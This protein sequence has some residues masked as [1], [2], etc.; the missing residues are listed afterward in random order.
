MCSIA[1]LIALVLATIAIVGGAMAAANWGGPLGWLAAAALIAGAI[2]ML[3]WG[4][5]AAFREYANCRDS[6]EGGSSCG[7]TSISNLLHAIRVVLGITATSFLTAAVIFWNIF[8]GGPVAATIALASGLVGCGVAIGLLLALL[9]T[10][11]SYKA[12]RDTE[13]RHHA[14]GET[15]ASA[16][17]PPPGQGAGSLT[18][19]TTTT[20]PVTIVIKAG[21]GTTI[22]RTP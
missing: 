19:T 12:C 2:A 6:A 13:K 21:P 8:A 10:L 5:D 3:T 20:G 9:A 11:Y 4:I 22:T 14:L 1:K 18:N 17:R 15:D 7:S 16:P